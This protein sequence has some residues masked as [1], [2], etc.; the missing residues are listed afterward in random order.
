[1]DRTQAGKVRYEVFGPF[2]FRTSEEATYQYQEA[3][4]VFWEDRE[5]D[6]S[7][8]GLSG[9][10][11]VYVWTV[12]RG[13]KRVPWNV[14][15]TDRQGFKKR[16]PQKERT[17]LRLLREQPD[18][19]IEVY[20]LTLRSKTGKFRKPTDSQGIKA[21]HW[22][23][24]MLIG[25]AISVNPYLRNIA[26]AGYLKNAVVDGY[27]NDSEEERSKA[28]RSFSALFKAQPRKRN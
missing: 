15:L 23:E 9:A 28:A 13:T 21:N 12:K 5:K 4:K 6:R 20:L 19:K 16:F 7:P 27:L 2:P 14:G 24:T 17:F 8:D 3:L 22:L 26:K 1:M 25:S 10:I 18:A 11:G